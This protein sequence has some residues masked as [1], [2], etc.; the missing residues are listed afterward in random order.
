MDFRTREAAL[1]RRNDELD[2]CKI[3]CSDDAGKSYVE[4]QIPIK[5]VFQEVEEANV[6]D[7]A[8]QKD[9]STDSTSTIGD[10]PKVCH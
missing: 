9:H 10:N 1:K 6:E 3:L 5:S 2:A 4:S 7:S 8:S